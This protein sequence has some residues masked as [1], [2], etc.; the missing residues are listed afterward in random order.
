MFTM[1]IRKP[2]SDVIKSVT[3]WYGSFFALLLA[4]LI[5]ARVA[6]PLW[7]E[8][9]ENFTTQLEL[10]FNSP[11]NFDQISGGWVGWSPSL[12]LK[13]LTVHDAGGKSNIFSA[14]EI[15]IRINIFQSLMERRLIFKRIKL[16]DSEFSILREV[17]GSLV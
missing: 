9:K 15:E 10:L 16:S 2:F 17:D 8:D 5:I 6:L 14:E 3:F 13:N 1:H 12:R 11:T 7:L 4:C